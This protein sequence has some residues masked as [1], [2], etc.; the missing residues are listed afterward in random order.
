MLYALSQSEMERF[1]NWDVPAYEYRSVEMLSAMFR[2]DPDVVRTILPKPLVPPDDP[3]GWAY[4]W[5]CPE[6]NV[7]DLSYTEGALFVRAV[8]KGEPG[9]YPLAVPVDDDMAMIGGREWMGFPKKIAEDISLE[10]T[11]NQVMGRVIRRGVEVLRI[12]AD[13]DDAVETPAFDAIGPEVDDLAGRP[14]WKLVAFVF[15]HFP[16][17]GGGFDYLPRLV[18]G[19][20]LCRPRDDVRSGTGRLELVSSPYDPLGD[21][22]VRDL[23]D[24]SY[25]TWDNDQLPGRVVAR[26]WNPFGFIRYAAFKADF[27][28]WAFQQDELPVRPGRRERRRRKKAIK[29]Y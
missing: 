5:R 24:V 3:V 27:A 6:S 20:M 10:R 2:T 28:G 4:V 22:P 7:A 26:V 13:L 16:S 21:I 11:G 25:G 12:E 8:Y 17:P 23:L 19:V 14:S 9:W 18:R 29:Q 1:R 15:K